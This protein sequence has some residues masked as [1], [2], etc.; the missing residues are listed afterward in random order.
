MF[1]QIEQA[2]W[3]YEV[4]IYYLYCVLCT[5]NPCVPFTIPQDF[6]ADDPINN[7]LPK[8]KK[9]QAFAE[10]LFQ[11]CALLTPLKDKLDILFNDFCVYRWQ[12]PVCGCIL[13]NPVILL[14]VFDIYV[15]LCHFSQLACRR[16]RMWFLCEIGVEAAGELMIIF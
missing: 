5:F 2:H 13:V 14:V 8:F 1:F 16:K 10:I 11:R 7:H 15:A 9:L 4:R 3:F 6:I 12:I